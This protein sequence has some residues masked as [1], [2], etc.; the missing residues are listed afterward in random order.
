MA[1]RFS[2]DMGPGQIPIDFFV[3]ALS[4]REPGFAAAAM[5]F[6]SLSLQISFTLFR[7]V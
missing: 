1:G 5:P 7:N 4:P 3:E 6:R 2:L